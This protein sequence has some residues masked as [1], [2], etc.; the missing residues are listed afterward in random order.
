MN[1]REAIQYTYEDAVQDA[2]D[3]NVLTET[4]AEEILEREFAVR[5]LGK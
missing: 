4:L 5:I 1:L 2:V 3:E